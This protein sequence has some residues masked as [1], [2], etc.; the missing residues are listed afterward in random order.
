MPEEA[1]PAGRVPDVALLALVQV[2][3]GALSVA[4]KFV[5]PEIGPL[6]LVA[7]RTGGAA[8]VLVALERILV[9]HRYTRAELPVIAGLSVLGVALNQLFFL[10]GLSMTTAVEATVLVTTIPVFTMAV[11]IAWGRERWDARKG[12][13]MG[14]A[15]A[16]VIVLVGAGLAFGSQ[17]LLGN[18]FVVMNAF[19]YSIFLVASRPVLKRMPPLSLTAGTFAVAAVLLLPVG[20]YGLGH[21]VPG[22]PDAVGW[23]ALAF[24]IL[25]PSVTSYFLV[26]Y[27]LSRVPA[28]VVAAF[29]YLQPLVAGVL[30]VLLL[31][32]PITTSLLAGGGLIFVGVGIAAIA[33]GRRLRRYVPAE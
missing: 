19:F 15:F 5:I 12:L 27:A 4:G 23:T 32:E 29:I 17:T 28:S 25:G 21:V 1:P 9:G 2:L 24:I 31:H 30:A 14:V 13:G 8:I 7:A 22:K 33:P 18:L 20:L 10:V 3:F 11:G 16:G 6:V 26:S